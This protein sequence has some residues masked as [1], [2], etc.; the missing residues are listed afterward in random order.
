M[1]IPVSNG[2]PP[3]LVVRRRPIASYSS[4]ANP[5]GSIVLWQLAQTAFVRCC[6]SRSRTERGAPF[7]RAPGRLGTSGGGGEGGVPRK[8]S[9]SHTPRTT[10]DVRFAYDVIVRRL[11]WPSSPPLVSSG[12]VTRRKCTPYTSGIP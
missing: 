12:Q 4:R 5:S 7:S 11:A 1:G 8:F 9:S 2:V 10:G 3:P 6:S